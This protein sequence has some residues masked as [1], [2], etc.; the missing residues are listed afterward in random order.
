MNKLIYIYICSL[1]LPRHLPKRPLEAHVIMGV[2]G[3]KYA[4]NIFDK[5]S[6]DAAVVNDKDMMKIQNF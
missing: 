1:H 4:S 2:P 6:S 3:V 5:H